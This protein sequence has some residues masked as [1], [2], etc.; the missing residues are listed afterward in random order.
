MPL[1]E[2]PPNGLFYRGSGR[3]GSFMREYAVQLNS[4]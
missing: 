4:V 2:Q 1:E 3:K